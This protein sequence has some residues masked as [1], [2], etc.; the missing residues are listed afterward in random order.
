LAGA[1]A[2]VLIWDGCTGQLQTK[3]RVV[4]LL[5]ALLFASI[6]GLVLRLEG[7]LGRILRLSKTHAELQAEAQWAGGWQSLHRLLAVALVLILAVMGI[8]L[9]AMLSRLEPG[10]RIFG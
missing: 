3:Y 2:A 4:T 9:V 8:G 7:L 10:F 1:N 6:G 5:V